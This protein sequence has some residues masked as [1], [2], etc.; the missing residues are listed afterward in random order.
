MWEPDIIQ[1]LLNSTLILIG[2]NLLKTYLNNLSSLLPTDQR[3]Q[4][5]KLKTTG[6][7][8]VGQKR[9]FGVE[10]ATHPYIVFM[11]YYPISIYARI[12]VLLTYPQ[13]DL[14]GVADLD[15]YDAVSDGCAKVISPYLSEASM[16]FKKSFWRERKFLD[17]FNTLGEGYTFT[18]GRRNSLIKMPSCFNLIAITH[19]SNY[20]QTNR[21]IQ[22]L[23]LE[24][25]N[26]LLKVLDFDTRLFILDLFSKK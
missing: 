22:E 16:A 1:E 18:K 24:K 17:K 7:L 20:T 13:Y 8:S 19:D 6:R 9:N 5:Y 14:V 23:N 3:I 25:K 12:A 15:V 10:H 2:L 21:S 4:Y 11:D 26:S